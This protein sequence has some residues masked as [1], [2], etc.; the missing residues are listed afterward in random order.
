MSS[1]PLS[2]R[3]GILSL[4][5]VFAFAAAFFVPIVNVRILSVEEYGFYRQFWLLFGTLTPIL[6]LGFPRSLLYYFPRSET[7]REKSIYVTQTVFYLFVAGAAAVLVYTILGRVLGAGMGEMIRAFYWRLCFFTVFMLLARHME[8]LFVADNQVERQALYYVVTSVLRA[9]VVIAVALNMRDL[10]AII[11]ALAAFALA[12]GAFA[13]IY[14][15]IAYR[16]SLRQV[17]LA[18]ISEQFSFALPL[19]LMYVA[20]LLLAQS[21]KFIINRFMGREAFAIYSVGA[22]QLPIANIIGSSVASI[23]FPLMARYQKERRYDDFVDLWK[24]SWMKTAVLFFPI[25]V[26]LMVTAEQFIVIL[27]TDKYAEAVPVFRIYLILFL[28]TTTDFAGVLTAFKQ[29]AYLFK[30][31]AVAVVV[32]VLLSIVL[33]KTW[34]WLG[35]PLSTTLCFFVVAALAV[36]KGSRL[37][38]YSIWRVV[39][40]RG[41]LARMAAAVVPGVGL[42]LAYA[43]HGDHGMFHYALA[44]VAYFAV[45]FAI[46]W[47][48]RMLRLGDVKS[49]LGRS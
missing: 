20:V 14:T 9:A 44:G 6:V 17:S 16:P 24:R 8:E 15:K 3:V 41:L 23:A 37:L 28:K 48:F 19:G 39:P 10:S 43:R 34:G 33:F 36:L 2:Q 40:W 18:T 13:V 47:S 32:N 30:V 29:Q 38:G 42:Y 45:Y 26:F 25:F 7:A 1:K 4:G 22:F 21:D 12:K 31:S 11:W 27:F 5:R 49:L 35:V 46:C